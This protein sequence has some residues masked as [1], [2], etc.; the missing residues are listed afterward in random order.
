MAARGEERKEVDVES[1]FSRWEAT[2]DPAALHQIV[3]VC[4]RNPENILRLS[5]RHLQIYRLLQETRQ[6]LTEVKE[7]LEEKQNAVRQVAAFIGEGPVMVNGAPTV[8]VDRGGQRSV[9]ALAEGISLDEVREK[10]MVLLNQDG[11]LVVGTLD[12][13]E[14]PAEIGRVV[15]VQNGH[16]LV[17][18]HADE[19]VRVD[20]SHRLRG[21]FREGDRVLVDRRHGLA[22]GRMEAVESQTEWLLEESP[23]E[24]FADVAAQEEAIRHIVERVFYPI[25]RPDL[26]ELMRLHHA[27]GILLYGPSGCGK[28]LIGRATAG[29]LH[30][31]FGADCVFIRIKA[32]ALKSKWYGETVQRIQRLWRFARSEAKK[33]KIVIIFLDECDSLGSARAAYGS[34]YGLRADHDATNA[35]L[36]EMEGIDTD[37]SQRILCIASTNFERN[38]DSA[39]LGR[40]ALQIHIHRPDADGADRMFH[41]H[42]NHGDVPMELPLHQMIEQTVD[43]IFHKDNALLQAHMRD[44]KEVE[45]IRRSHLVTGRLVR[46]CVETSKWMVVSDVIENGEEPVLRVSH[47]L[48]ALEEQFTEIARKLTPWNVSEFVDLPSVRDGQVARLTPVVTASAGWQYVE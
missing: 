42:L 22:V 35:W 48:R 38:L 12:G 36:G 7:T 44:G 18:F 28:T 16:L 47:L 8:I 11:S 9:V 15:E 27:V 40:F 19:Q 33:G 46:D 2:G 43:F 17:E 29:E 39:F 1:I 41:I 24:R 13:Y 26:I 25:E 23:P 21:Q 37:R 31:K 14:P 4:H 34:E 32:G 30:Q 6:V 5:Q 3:E 45:T 10:S 20:V